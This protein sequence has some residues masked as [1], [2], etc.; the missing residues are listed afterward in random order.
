MQEDEKVSKI[1]YIKC[2]FMV[3]NNKNKRHRIWERPDS[4]DIICEG[5]LNKNVDDIQA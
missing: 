5:F 2:N 1:N 3:F 4:K